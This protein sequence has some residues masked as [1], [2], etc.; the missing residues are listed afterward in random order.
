M[1]KA[2]NSFDCVQKGPGGTKCLP[3]KTEIR[4]CQ[5]QVIGVN[6]ECRYQAYRGN[7]KQNHTGVDSRSGHI[8]A[9][10]PAIIL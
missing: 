5:Y 10:K 3:K 1:E 2:G 9:C 7:A 6:Q 8:Q 4:I